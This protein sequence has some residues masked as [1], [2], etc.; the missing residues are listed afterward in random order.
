MKR[1]KLSFC[2]VIVLSLF[3]LWLGGCKS[4]DEGQ[5]S[6]L[7]SPQDETGTKTQDVKVV[8]FSPTTNPVRITNSSVTTYVVSVNSHSGDVEYV[9]KLNGSTLST[10]TDPFLDLSGAIAP[11]GTSTLEVIASNS[12]SEDSKIFAIEKNTPPVIDAATP[13]STGNTLSCGSGTLAMTVSA[14]DVN[15]DGLTFTWLLNGA[16]HATY[17]S[18]SGTGGTSTN[19]FSPPCSVAGSN[20]VSVEVSD[21]YDK[22]STSW[23]ITV[24]NPTVANIDSFTPATSP[25]IIPSAGS[26]LFSIS[27]SGKAPLSYSWKVDGT[28]IPGE[29][30]AFITVS[31][32]SL[33]VGNHILTA[34][35]SDADSSDTH[36]FQVKRNAPPVF[37]NPSPNP[38][39]TTKL[40]Y[41]S[42]KTFAID[43][44]D[45][46]GDA[47]TYS[48]YLDGNPHSS[49]AASATPSGHQAV[50]S[51]SSALVG[52][53]VILVSATDGTETAQQSWN[54]NVNY[55]SD[56][57]NGLSSGEICTIIGKP[58][59][60]EGLYPSV[61]GTKVKMRP[62]DVI[63]DG[64][65]NLFITDDENHVV[66][67]YNR[68]GSSITRLGKTIAA[69]QIVAIIGNGSTGVGPSGASNNS[70]KL[71]N[72]YGVAWDAARENL[73]VSLYSD[74]TVVRVDSSGMVHH[75]VCSGSGN[76]PGGNDGGLASTHKCQNPANIV[77]D[78]TRKYLYVAVYGGHQVKMF[79]VSDADSA[80]WTGH[81]MI[82]T[83]NRNAGG[84]TTSDDG[85]IGTAR[86]VNPYAMS[87]DSN[88]VVYYTDYGGKCHLRVINNTGS[89]YSYMNGT[90]VVNS[91]QVK[92]ITNGGSCNSNTGTYASLQLYQP[93]GLSV[94]SDGVNVY[95]WFVTNRN[96]DRITYVN[97]HS[98]DITIGGQLVASYQGDFVW[99]ST[100]TAG[101]GGES[102]PAKNNATNEPWGV[103]VDASGTKVIIADRLNFR[104][105]Q[106]DISVADGAL[107]TLAGGGEKYGFNGGSNS[108]ASS[109]KMNNPTKILFDSVNNSI[110]FSD[111]SN[112]RIRSVN[113]TTGEENTIVG[114]GNSGAG[115]IEDEDPLNVNIQGAH[116]LVLHGNALLFADKQGGNG[117]NRNCLVRA[118]NRS[119]AASTLFNT[120]ISGG[121][122]ST[123]AGNY[124]LGCNSYS[125]DM[126]PATAARLAQ[127]EGIASDGTNLYI[128]LYNDHCIV[129]VDPSGVVSQY[130]GTCGSAGDVNG[131]ATNTSVRL[132]NPSSII[133]DPRHPT[134]LFIADQTNQGTNKIKY[135]NLSGADVSIS[136]ITIS[137]GQIGSI[138]SGDGYGYGVAAF[139]NQVCYTSGHN[140]NGWS[141]AHN[142]QCK[143]RDNPI[144]AI[145]MLAGRPD[146]DQ[147]KA[148]NQSNVE[149]EGVPATSSTLWTPYGLT[150]DS[151]GNLYI[152][153]RNNHII[154]MVKKWW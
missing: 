41:Q 139:D 11:A 120:T 147:T 44:S 32:A 26:Q 8:S 28:T 47:I 84:G 57:C 21:G 3:S 16:P 98:S 52:N 27:A 151:Q 24:N 128:S 103:T 141:G 49:L 73:F 68:S 53:H 88:G 43:A 18:I 85:A 126:G 115:N 149:Q 60:G 152:A 111:S 10:G 19:S 76:D 131:L 65:G 39:V 94:L 148:G 99:N 122:V 51:P 20:T 95:G 72:P 145:T 140:S 4:S 82:G 25:I 86:G 123:I 79:D 2:L 130:I 74:H 116:G 112:Q 62:T 97:N 34:V 23:A 7:D 105:R 17:F 117:V 22:V 146:G 77:Y 96:H 135:V 33:S 143:N 35:V 109:V 132:R 129:K 64:S 78:P 71:R 134:N 124:I 113:L 92:T 12:Q 40:N 153:D 15:S 101:Y 42:F 58:G 81:Y 67:F 87:I 31:A 61:D 138:F 6:F 46:N 29:N 54:V 108:P 119:G 63:D 136:G 56:A 144:P 104:I 37:T 83:T 80:N 118:Y 100:T 125:G 154:R 14:S 106:L 59:Y 70:Y 107:T 48:W 30:S 102:G 90:V 55:F 150:F 9:W 142:V 75:D 45:G 5:F 127:P 13:S 50:F 91:G 114:R 93:R 121:R 89:N 66:W 69:G 38:G 137:T 133:M 1:N 36:D 110:V